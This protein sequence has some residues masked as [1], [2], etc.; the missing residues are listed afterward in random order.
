METYPWKSI[1]P[2]DEL[3]I[4]S[5]DSLTSKD[6]HVLT[7]LYQPLIGAQEIGRASCRERV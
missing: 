4:E 5:L 1:D 7:K 6:V 2:K 3:Q